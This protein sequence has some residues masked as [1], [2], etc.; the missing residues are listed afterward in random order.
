MRRWICGPQ[1]GRSNQPERQD[2]RRSAQL[3]GGAWHAIDD[4]TCLI[5]RNGMSTR[6]ADLQQ[7]FSSVAP[8]SG[9]Q[10]G[11]RCGAQQCCGQKQLINSGPVPLDQWR[12]N[13][14]ECESRLC[15]QGK[16]K[17]TRG[18]HMDA[19]R[20]RKLP[21]LRQYH[22]SGTGAV[23]TADK[24]FDKSGTHVLNH[25]SWWAV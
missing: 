24:A 17:V 4:G 1:Q 7:A 12:V 3:A 5:L 18:G 23:Q 9:Q 25:K 8:H 6:A 16:M 2:L 15:K 22:F 19:A 13:Q 21:I 10:G 11:D 20:P 14:P